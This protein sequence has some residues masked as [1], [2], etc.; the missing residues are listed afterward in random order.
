MNQLEKDLL[1]CID[2][3]K[4][5][6]ILVEKLVLGSLKKVVEDSSNK[7]DD[8]AFAYLEPLVKVQSEKILADL[9]AKIK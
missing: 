7:F 1:S 8:V 5:S 6:I 2:L 4:L 9:I 3:S